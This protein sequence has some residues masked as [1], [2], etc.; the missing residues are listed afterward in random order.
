MTFRERLEELKESRAYNASDVAEIA[1]D[2]I[3]AIGAYEIL[4]EA[5]KILS[6][7]EEIDLLLDVATNFDV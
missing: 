3:D 6:S 2:M 4:T 1:M 7:A 5:L